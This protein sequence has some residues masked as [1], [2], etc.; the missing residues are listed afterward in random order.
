[1]KGIHIA[2]AGAGIKSPE[3]GINT[4]LQVHVTAQFAQCHIRLF[5]KQLGV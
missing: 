4:L 1:M 3:P 5:E 2:F